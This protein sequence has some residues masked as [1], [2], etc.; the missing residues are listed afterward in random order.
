M[1]NPP[2]TAIMMVSD[3]P[4]AAIGIKKKPPPLMLSDSGSQK[5]RVVAENPAGVEV[6]FARQWC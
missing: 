3:Q 2:A 6:A 5:K 1:E 4:T